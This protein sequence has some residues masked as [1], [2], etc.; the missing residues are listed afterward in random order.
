MLRGSAF[1]NDHVSADY[2]V[3]FSAVSTNQQF[4]A[5]RASGGRG[6]LYFPTARLEVGASYGRQLQN[7][8][9]NFEGFTFGGSRQHRA[10]AALGI[11]QRCA[12]G[13]LLGRSRLPLIPLQK[14]RKFCGP[15]RT[16]VPHA[17]D[18]P[19][20]ARFERWASRG[21]H[22]GQISV[23][24]TGCHM[25]CESTPAIPVNSLQQGT[26]ISGK[27]A[28]S[29]DFYFLPGGAN[30]AQFDTSH[31]SCRRNR[32]SAAVRSAGCKANK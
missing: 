15:V 31:M 7:V 22:T 10:Q 2:A 30:E 28:S 24:I 12:R 4:T 27:P 26:G 5:E 21:R 1:A 23:S 8:H 14:W 11:L 3:Y 6:S 19:L 20:S 13:R 32:N 25:K 29:I 18:V 16:G 9:E 17:A